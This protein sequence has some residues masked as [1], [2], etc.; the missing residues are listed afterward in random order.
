MQTYALKMCEQVKLSLPCFCCSCGWSACQIFHAGWPWGYFH[1]SEVTE[2][3]LLAGVIVLRVFFTV[4][5]I[6][7]SRLWSWQNIVLVVV[8]TFFS[9]FCVFLWEETLV[10]N[11]VTCCSK[12]SLLCPNT[13]VLPAT[14]AQ[15]CRFHMANGYTVTLYMIILFC[16]TSQVH[17]KAWSFAVRE[18][19]GHSSTGM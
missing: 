11:T 5:A 7:C 19:G 13:L 12:L 2:K 6:W 14:L 9:P 8:F 17:Q 3:F 16:R 18:A 10:G 15:H 4:T 1:S